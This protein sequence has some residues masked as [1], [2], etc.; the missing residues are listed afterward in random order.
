MNIKLTEQQIKLIVEILFHPS[1]DQ[2]LRAQA[3][4]HLLGGAI[5]A[6]I[7]LSVFQWALVWLG[8]PASGAAFISWV[9]SLITSWIVTRW[10]V[11]GEV[12]RQKRNVLFQLFLFCGVALVSLGIIQVCIFIFT[13]YLLVAPLVAKILSLPIVFMWTLSVSRCIV[14]SKK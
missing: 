7:D 14:F 6:V 10:Y 11:F 5:V 4:R 8:A 13:N 2:S 12:K 1:R 9:I 3:I